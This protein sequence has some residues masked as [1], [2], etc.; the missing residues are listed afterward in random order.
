M[1]TIDKPERAQ[2]LARAI[3]SDIS[4]YNEDAVKDG[5]INDSFFDA[6]G[7]ELKEG[8]DLYAS[9]VSPELA[10]KSNYFERAIIDVIIGS[11]GHI[12]SKL[13]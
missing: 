2:R 4:L 7:P 1:A 11:K 10:I 9:R 12:P 8:R 5:I 6:V 13:W 3:A